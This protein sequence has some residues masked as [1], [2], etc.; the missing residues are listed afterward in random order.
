MVLA[1]Y[2]HELLKGQQDRDCSFLVV[3]VAEKA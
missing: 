3:V 1:V 2:V